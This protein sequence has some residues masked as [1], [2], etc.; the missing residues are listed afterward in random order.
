[1]GEYQEA[2]TAFDLSSTHVHLGLGATAVAI[3][4]FCWTPESLQAYGDRFAADGDE[5]RIVCIVPQEATWDSWERHPAG[6]H[7]PR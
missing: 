6:E 2:G 4:E 1:M 7:R 3:P 5:G